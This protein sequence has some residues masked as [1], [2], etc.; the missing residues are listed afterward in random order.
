MYH[1]AKTEN[2]RKIPSEKISLIANR[3]EENSCRMEQSTMKLIMT[4]LP[5]IPILSHREFN[6]IHIY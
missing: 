6:S 3:L 5:Y 1:F 4:I 2:V